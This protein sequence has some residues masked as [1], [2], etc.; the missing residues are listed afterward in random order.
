[1]DINNPTTDWR[2]T[3]DQFASQHKDGDID[4]SLITIEKL[5]KDSLQEFNRLKLVSHFIFLY[6][7]NIIMSLRN[8][9]TIDQLGMLSSFLT[10][11]FQTGHLTGKDGPLTIREDHVIPTSVIGVKLMRNLVAGV[12]HNQLNVMYV[13]S[14]SN[15]FKIYPL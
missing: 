4:G 11:I 14:Q 5:L 12:K 9:V 10:P 7:M 15:F 1:M 2:E 8:D 6:A 3:W 13:T